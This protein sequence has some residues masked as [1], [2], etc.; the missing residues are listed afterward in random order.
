M[1]NKIDLATEDVIEEAIN[2]IR[3]FNTQCPIDKV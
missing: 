1:L 3:E 2:K